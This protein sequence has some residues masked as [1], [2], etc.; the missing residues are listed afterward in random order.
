MVTFDHRSILLGT[1]LINVHTNN[2]YAGI[3]SFQIH[4]L[5]KHRECVA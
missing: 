1:K 4:V 2:A 3:L 5:L